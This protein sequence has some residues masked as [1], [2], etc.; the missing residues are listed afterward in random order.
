MT[1]P[2]SLP[3]QQIK[4]LIYAVKPST[5]WIGSNA[6]IHNDTHHMIYLN[7]FGDPLTFYHEKQVKL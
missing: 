5:I 7:I 4:V 6:C 1:E 2:L 3:R